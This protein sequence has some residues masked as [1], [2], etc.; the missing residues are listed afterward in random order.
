MFSKFDGEVDIQDGLDDH[1]C[2]RLHKHERDFFFALFAEA[3]IRET[4]EDNDSEWGC[5]FG[6]DWKVL[7]E[8]KFGCAA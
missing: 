7:F 1:Y 4:S 6:G 2:A 3:F 8:D 5:A